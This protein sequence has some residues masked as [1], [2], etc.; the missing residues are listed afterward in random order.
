LPFPESFVDVIQDDQ[1]RARNMP[2]DSNL[3]DAHIVGD[4]GA[5]MA[6]SARKIDLSR[7]PAYGVQYGRKLIQTLLAIEDLIRGRAWGY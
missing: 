7:P 2:F 6:G 1:K 5:G 3:C 4:F